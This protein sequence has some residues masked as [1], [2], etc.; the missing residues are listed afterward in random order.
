MASSDPSESAE[1]RAAKWEAA[2]L[3]DSSPDFVLRRL[4]E[5]KQ[6]TAPWLSTMTP[7]E[8]LVAKTHHIT[9]LAMVAG[10]CFYHYGFSWTEGHAAGWQMALARI[11]R[12]A[13]ACGANAVVDVKMRTSEG[14]A[15]HSMDFT[16][17]GTAIKV[18]VFTYLVRSDHC[19]GTCA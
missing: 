5:A 11:R 2:L 7:A 14:E 16:L 12:E 8:L 17:F 9:P 1:I 18:E 10:T 4:D 6:G 19:D 3:Q 13:L 15:G